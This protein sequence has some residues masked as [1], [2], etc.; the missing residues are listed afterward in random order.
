MNKTF[1]IICVVLS[2]LKVSAQITSTTNQILTV[3]DNTISKDY[4]LENGATVTIYGFKK[5]GDVYH[6][7]VVTNDFAQVISS[8]II[9][10]NVDEKSLKKLPN[11]LSNDMKSLLFSRRNDIIT[12]KKQQCKQDAING[13]IMAIVD[14]HY[15]LIGREDAKGTVSLG[16]TIHIVGYSGFLS[17]HEYALYSN[18][19]VGVYSVVGRDNIFQQQIET[20]FLPPISD[21]DVKKVLR[22][23]E[24][25]LQQKQEELKAQY[26]KDALNGKIK[27]VVSGSF[28]SDDYLISPFKIGE[29]VSVV[30]YSKK[31]SRDYYALYTDQ[32]SVKK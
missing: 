32:Y 15:S 22:Q 18:N 28:T 1:L 27:G 19:A 21:T 11:A 2:S 12:T 29:I 25:E 3:H 10:F 23:K 13:K 30:G 31:D 5:K 17:S 8:N 4:I 7:A 20:D 6:F 16:D 26:R 14:Q 9:P 24:L